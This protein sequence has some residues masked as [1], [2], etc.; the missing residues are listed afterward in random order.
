MDPENLFSLGIFIFCATSVNF[1][2]FFWRGNFHSEETDK[3]KKE[4]ELK[5]ERRRDE[6]KE[7]EEKRGKRK[8]GKGIKGHRKRKKIWR[9]QK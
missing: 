8:K 3:R 4:E 2:L 9:K 7:K 1:P 6:E 5:E